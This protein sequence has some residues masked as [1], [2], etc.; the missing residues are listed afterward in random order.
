[1]I[2][3]G[4]IPEWKICEPWIYDYSNAPMSEQIK[5]KPKGKEQGA[6][7]EDAPPEVVKAYE[8]VQELIRKYP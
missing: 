8:Y 5:P 2:L 3:L 7:R 4:E 1:M 6:L